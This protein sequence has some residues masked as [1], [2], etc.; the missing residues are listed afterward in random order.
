MPAFPRILTVAALAVA[1]GPEPGDPN[2]TAS[3]TGTAS[4]TTPTTTDIPTTGEPAT[5][6]PVQLPHAPPVGTQH[7]YWYK[8]DEIEPEDPTIQ[9]YLVND[10]APCNEDPPGTCDADD[11][12]Q[13][14]GYFAVLGPDEQAPGVYP[15]SDDILS[16]TVWIG[17]LMNEWN[18][19]HC[20][21]ALFLAAAADGEIEVLAND[22]GCI[23]IDIRGVTPIPHKGVVLDPN[24]SG[25]VAQCGA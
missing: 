25:Q 20:S 19:E 16:D 8:L 18:G 22:G 12:V 21:L 23:A 13:L 4:T 9:V 15:I 24:G 6:S 11:P 17:A 1:C 3:D 14:Y 7:S 2:A 5:C 10:Q